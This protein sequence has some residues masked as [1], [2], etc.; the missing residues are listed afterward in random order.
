MKPKRVALYVRVSTGEQN[1]D[2][3]VNELNEYAA[4]RKW[5]TV[6]IYADKMSGAKDRRPALDRLMADAKRGK[7][8]AVAVWRFDR[9]AR[10]TSHLLRA[11]EEFEALG[12]DFVSLKESIDTSTPTGKM[13]FTV[14]AA[15]AELERSTIRERVLAGQKAARRRGVRFGR[16]TVDIDVEAV[17]KLRDKGFSWRD[18]S[19]EIGVPT[20]TIIRHWQAL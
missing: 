2:L 6:E 3:Q 4:F 10:S 11:L 9:F 1:A 18:I 12:I 5:E 14:L 19:H 16:P 15:V 20:D 17:R 13:V 7:F 8:D